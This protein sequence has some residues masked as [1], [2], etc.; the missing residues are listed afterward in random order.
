MMPARR[1]AYGIIL[2][3]QGKG[4]SRPAHPLFQRVFAG[5]GRRSNFSGFV[6]RDDVNG[7]VGRSDRGEVAG[8]GGLGAFGGC[9]SILRLGGF[10]FFAREHALHGRYGTFEH[11]VV[12]LVGGKVLHLHARP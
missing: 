12:G 9:G 3:R 10:G 5:R 7:F 11:A 8:V 6:N 4:N 2:S 1:Y